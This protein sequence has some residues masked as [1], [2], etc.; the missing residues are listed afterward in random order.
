[1]NP[2]GGSGNRPPPYYIDAVKAQDSKNEQPYYILNYQLNSQPSYFPVQRRRTA[3]ELDEEEKWYC[4][5]RCGKFYRKT[6]TKS[7]QKHRVTCTGKQEDE[8]QTST[9]RPLENKQRQS[10]T[11]PSLTTSDQLSD[12]KGSATGYRILQDG[13]ERHDG[14]A[15]DQYHTEHRYDD[16]GEVSRRRSSHPS[17]YR[18]IN[19]PAQYDY[20][21]AMGKIS[22]SP[23]VNEGSG[24][25]RTARY[26]ERPQS[27]HHSSRQPAFKQAGYYSQMQSASQRIQAPPQRPG[28]TWYPFPHAPPYPWPPVNFSGY[29]P[30]PP[31]LWG[32]AS[33]PGVYAPSSYPMPYT[34]YI[35]PSPSPYYPHYP[36]QQHVVV[37]TQQQDFSSIASNPKTRPPQRHNESFQTAYQFSSPSRLMHRN[38]DTMT[39]AMRPGTSSIYSEAKAPNSAFKESSDYSSSDNSHRIS[40]QDR[41]LMTIAA[42]PVQSRS[43]LENAEAPVRKWSAVDSQ[44][45]SPSSRKRIRQMPPDSN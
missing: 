40:V 24:D 38:P 6:S 5:K 11:L 39:P 44:L 21:S 27:E 16:K 7:I 29:P 15:S 9:S 25:T 45:Q 20:G 1:M 22:A 17:E 43:N 14:T 10:G 32:Y 36:P 13:R 2:S 37:Q 34:K 33:Y 12:P 31:Y 3:D 30:P 8:S 4:P 26:K 42:T 19:T 23:G 35:P 41:K 18:V 28:V